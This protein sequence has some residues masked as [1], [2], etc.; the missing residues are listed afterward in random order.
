MK[1]FFGILIGLAILLSY[2]SSY[3][4]EGG[5]KEETTLTAQLATETASERTLSSEETEAAQKA[6]ERAERAFDSRMKD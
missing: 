5:D 3:G 6:R 1:R 4:A 2:S